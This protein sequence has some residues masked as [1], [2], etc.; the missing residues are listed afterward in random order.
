MS[1]TLGKS[2][3]RSY[4]VR[5]PFMD[6]FYNIG[7]FF[8]KRSDFVL[9]RLDQDFPFDKP[10]NSDISQSV[11]INMFKNLESSKFCEVFIELY[12]YR[13]A[14]LD[15][16]NQFKK[17]KEESNESVIYLLNETIN[18]FK[19]EFEDRVFYDTLSLYGLTLSSYS[20]EFIFLI[21]E[22]QNVVRKLNKKIVRTR[23]LQISTTNS[24]HLLED[25]HQ[26]NIQSKNLGIYQNDS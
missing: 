18:L 15:I 17:V 1:L 21:A 9:F 26:H 22:R 23:A 20:N 8:N 24:L 4:Y 19:V 16:I 3:D 25:F 13:S 6:G 5:L 11:K 7:V 14:S 12:S 10:K 2:F